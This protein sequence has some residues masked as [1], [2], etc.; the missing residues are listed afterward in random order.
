MSQSQRQSQEGARLAPSLLTLYPKRVML[1]ARELSSVV[2]LEASG[3][4]NPQLLTWAHELLKTKPQL[5]MNSLLQQLIGRAQKWRSLRVGDK[6]GSAE[7]LDKR[8]LRL[9]F[10][11]LLAEVK[12]AELESHDLKVRRVIGWI[13]D[14][15][16]ALQAR[17]LCDDTRPEHLCLEELFTKMRSLSDEAQESLFSVA[18]QDLLE[19]LHRETQSLLDREYHRSRPQD[20]VIAQRSVWWTLLREELSLPT[21]RLHLFDGW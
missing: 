11:E 9:A 13:A 5:N 3:I 4:P 10:E 2:Q 16:S 14:Q 8:S 12:R 7:Q 20:F 19:R 15:I 18:P 1:N 21:L 6:F 17:A